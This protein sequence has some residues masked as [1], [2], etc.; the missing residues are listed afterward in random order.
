MDLKGYPFEGGAEK[1]ILNQTAFNEALGGRETIRTISIKGHPARLC[2]VPIRSDGKIIGVVQVA[3]SLTSVY[4][5]LRHLS[6]TVL[7]I[8][9]LALLLAGLC[10]AL[11]TGRALRPVRD[12]TVAARSISADNL[13]SRLPVKGGD[14]F[15][16]LASTF[17]STLDRL[18]DAIERL[19]ESLE[20][21]RRLTADASHELRTPL[22]VI[23]AHTS[24]ALS[25][26]RTVAQSTATIRT[27]DQAADIMSRIVQDLLLLARADA[28]Q[29]AIQNDKILLREA[30]GIAIDA[31]SALD[32]PDAV[33]G[34]FDPEIRVAG[35]LHLLTRV[36][37]NILSNA[38]R[39]TPPDGSVTLDASVEGGR[40]T[41][42]VTDTGEG[43]P[44]EALPHIG[45]RFYRVDTSRA[46]TKGG[47]GLGLAICRTIVEA[48]AGTL[49][50]E[51]IQGDGT[52]VTV[53]L[54]QALS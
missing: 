54:P 3:R 48:H 25:S 49:S 42:K 27:I 6:R 4:D 30:A 11:L 28:G 23:K 15:A 16:E 38:K 17:N 9:P 7:L 51:S 43:I 20:Q 33:I 44:P 24:L 29:L 18:Q 5:E 2:T 10:G 19:A 36:F 45:E 46:R 34:A 31:V 26:K 8:S 13:N 47:T 40:V 53:V 41:V 50:I 39:H 1:S 37:T 14:E 52:V 32:G 21:Q 12:F 35:D 22:T